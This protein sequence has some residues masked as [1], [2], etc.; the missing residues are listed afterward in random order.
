[1]VHTEKVV[2]TTQLITVDDCSLEMVLYVKEWFD[3]SN[4]AYH[5]LSMVCR[6]LPRSWK[7]KDF[8][9]CLNSLWKIKPCPEGY[10]MQQSLESRLTERVHH[11]LHAKRLNAGDKLKVKLSGDGTRVCREAKSCQF[12]IHSSQ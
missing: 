10:G 12:Q 8:V 5:E 7:M 1:M 6:G 4:A 3:L 2:V 11:L 9:Q